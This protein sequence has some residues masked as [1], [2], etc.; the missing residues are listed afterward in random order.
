[1]FDITGD[2]IARLNDA[3]FRTLV[4][5]LAIAELT[6]LKLPISAVTA[7][8]HQDAKDGGIDVRV[9]LDVPLVAPDFVPRA[10]TGFQVKKPDMPAGSISAE[11]R[12]HGVLRPAIAAL[13]DADGAYIIVS[14]QGSVTDTA[15]KERRKAMR[16]A[17]AGHP[18]AAAL[19]TDFYDRERIANW[20]NQFPGAAAWVRSKIGGAI[21]GWRPIGRWNDTGIAADGGYLLSDTA[22]LI[23]ERSKDANTLSIVDGIALLRT[24]LTAPRQCIRLIGMSG[25]GK[26]R[27]A[28]ALF[29]PGVGENPL[30]PALSVYTDYSD[31][32][33]PPA[34]EM[35]RRLVDSGQR[36]ILVVDNCNPAT[37][38]DLVTVCGSADSNV[39]LLTIEY[40]VR[41]DEPERTEVFRLTSASNSLITSWLER[42]FAHVSQVD[43]G[44]IAEFSAGNFRIAQALAE[45]LLRGETLGQLKNRQLFERIFIQRNAPDNQLLHDAE[46]LALLYSFD[47]ENESADGELARLATFGE[48]TV[49]ELFWSITDLRRRGII[50]SRGRWRAVLPQAIANPLAVGALERIPPGDF[51]T[52]CGAL[53]PR[54]LKSLS[55]RIGHLHDSKVAQA[56][57]ARWLSPDGALGELI[58]GDEGLTILRNIAPVL[59]E[60]VLSKIQVALD[61]ENGP[62]IL[63]LSNLQRWQWISLLKSLAFEPAM[64]ERAA[65]LLARFVMAEP[66]DHHSNSATGAFDELFRI[67]LSGT[68]APP[69]QRHTLARKLLESPDMGLLRAGMR[70]LNSLLNTGPFSSTSTFDFGARPRNFGWHP[71]I[72]DDVYSWY[73]EAINL[74]VDLAGQFEETK[75][76]LARNVPG[77]WH[78]AA[79]HNALDEASQRLASTGWVDGWIGFRSALRFD[80]KGMLDDI[81]DHLVAIIERLRPVDLLNRAR[82]FVLSRNS[83]GYDVVDGE[84]DDGETALVA[85]AGN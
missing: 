1:M 27:L 8:G 37:H 45:T 13:A 44:R 78:F 23:D 85:T 77:L 63:A 38:G 33:T 20:V 51:D 82:A 61:G 75:A 49:R 39:S 14:A 76:I 40:D 10:K 7:G 36:A 12:P 70:A 31:D 26:T 28:Q 60:A 53:P 2:D 35:A 81:R 22:C 24:S 64:F 83:G 57:V 71:K 52:F 84:D 59:L 16:D 32:I 79:C 62:S 50:Q 54:M 48:R 3:D 11:M 47:G 67:Y 19:F 80:G 29:E 18:K 46:V 5:R 72:K 68:M 58:S 4:A 66:P 55:R 17:L 30:D 74:A 25:L 41:D 65:T 42:D 43:R 69:E 21:A 9:D 34:R 73:D 6:T 15:L 56:I